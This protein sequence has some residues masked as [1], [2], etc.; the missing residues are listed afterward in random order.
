[1]AVAADDAADM[2][3]VAVFVVWRRAFLYDI[4]KCDHSMF[5]IFMEEAAGIQ[6]RDTDI[7]PGESP[8]I[9]TMNLYSCL[10]HENY[11]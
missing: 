5:K 2:G 4:C 1:M 7:F 10:I 3:A 11:L 9:L 8:G 6:D